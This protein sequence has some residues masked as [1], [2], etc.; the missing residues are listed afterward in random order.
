M[1][2]NTASQIL[3][4]LALVSILGSCASVKPCGEPYT[5]TQEFFQ[6]KKFKEA[7]HERDS[8]CE[9]TAELEGVLA[10]TEKD[11]ATTKDDLDRARAQAESLNK[12]LNAAKKSYDDLK[13][14]SGAQVAGLSSD[15]EAKQKELAEKEE[16]L[17]NREE[18]LKMLEEI[19]KK[20]DELMTALSDRVKKALMGFE[21]DELSVEMRDGKVYV[22]MSD[23]LLFK[24]GSDAVEPKGQ[25][26]L[27]KI[28]DVMKK[29][30]DIGMA[31]EGHTDSIP[32]KMNCFDDNWDLSVARATSVVRILTGN[33]IEP[34]RL[35]ASGKGEFSPR[36]SNSTKEGRAANRRT[37][38]VLSP[39]LNELMQLLGQYEQR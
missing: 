39:K 4:A 3:G 32:I 22:S 28:A 36:A 14:S 25:E 23:K 30:L 21:A 19:I 13:L 15:L 37:E 35:T 29:N 27:I 5:E 2:F 1:H 8:L 18:R 38:L 24:S 7:F 10:A 31:I 33:G 9:R 26:A 6:S 12:D 17:K 11:L 16:L 20:Q 34:D